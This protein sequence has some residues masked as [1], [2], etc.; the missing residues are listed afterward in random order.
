MKTL[1][2]LNNIQV[3]MTADIDEL[4]QFLLEYDGNIIDIQCTD[5]YF[6]VVYRYKD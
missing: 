5:K 4:N 3:Y 2:G 1:Y 6:H